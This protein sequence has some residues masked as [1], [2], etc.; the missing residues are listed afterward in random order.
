MESTEVHI[1]EQIFQTGGILDRDGNT[2]ESI[3]EARGVMFAIPKVSDPQSNPPSRKMKITG[4]K[5]GL[6]ACLS[7]ISKLIDACIA[8]HNF[9]SQPLVSGLTLKEKLGIKDPVPTNARQAY[10][11]DIYQARNLC[12]KFEI[13]TFEEIWHGHRRATDPEG[14]YENVRQAV[15]GSK[16]KSEILVTLLKSIVTPPIFYRT[17]GRPNAGSSQYQ[18]D[19]DASESEDGSEGLFDEANGTEAEESTEE[20]DDDDD[21]SEPEETPVVQDSTTFINPPTE[22]KS[23]EP[24]TD[25]PSGTPLPPIAKAKPRTAEKKKY[26]RPPPKPE[27]GCQKA[28]KKACV[29]LMLLPKNTIMKHLVKR[30]RSNLKEYRL[31]AAGATALATGLKHKSCVIEQLSVCNCDIEDAGAAALAEVTTKTARL[32]SLDL[33]QNKLGHRTAVALARGFRNRGG[34]S[35][36][37]LSDTGFGNTFLPLFAKA[38]KKSPCKLLSLNL[39]KCDISDRGARSLCKAI[40]QCVSL[41]TLNL[42]WNNIG[43]RSMYR[44]GDVISSHSTLINLH[45]A[46]NSLGDAGGI[47]FGAFLACSKSLV[48]VDVAENRLG[49]NAAFAI[50]DGIRYCRTMR[51][52]DLS[53]NPL[54]DDGVVELLHAR[55]ISKLN[56]LGLKGTDKTGGA[57]E[58]LELFLKPA[59][60]SRIY[61]MWL[62]SPQNRAFAQLLRLRAAEGG[63][64]WALA[65]LNRAVLVYKP[66]VGKKWSVPREGLL[67]IDYRAGRNKPANQ[68]HG[69]LKLASIHFKLD[70]SVARHRKMAERLILLAVVELGENWFNETFN[71]D[72]FEFDEQVH[73]AAWLPKEGVLEFD[74]ASANFAYNRPFRFDLSRKQEHERATTLAEKCFRSKLWNAGGMRDQWK[75]VKVK[76]E[77][78]SLAKYTKISKHERIQHGSHLMTGIEANFHL[79]SSGLLEFEY[80]TKSPAYLYSTPYTLD[81][82]DKQQHQEAEML[83]YRAAENP[84]EVWWGVLIDGMK[85]RLKNISGEFAIPKR[86][87]LTFDYLYYHTRA[88]VQR[89]YWQPYKFDLADKRQRQMC[90]TFHGQCAD[91]GRFDFFLSVSHDGKMLELKNV[92]EATWMVPKTGMLEFESCYFRKKPPLSNRE[93]RSLLQEVSCQNSELLKLDILSMSCMGKFFVTAA[94]VGMLC[95]T[96]GT[97][98]GQRDAVHTMLPFLSDL[99]LEKDV[100]EMLQRSTADRHLWVPILRIGNLGKVKQGIVLP[101]L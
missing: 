49:R 11:M 86:G 47:V 29:K 22:E 89:M 12:A 100:R 84:G 26:V 30:K 5:D 19:S 83:Y 56:F 17:R 33:S 8:R 16:K 79:P 93:F 63:N 18:D 72:P 70:L 24:E 42:D 77:S 71:G 94:M 2:L 15:V 76:G 44:L 75:N 82:S 27:K 60:E 39:S 88:V 57:H 34:L 69:D 95:R 31:G 73:T 59:N 9:W 1:P 48:N 98:E 21:E 101:P 55:K 87:I 41:E 51:S 14:F 46:W 90:I 78:A 52:L 54:G 20:E 40:P 85:A 25:G 43:P 80:C 6:H 32:Y 64:R 67:E 65:R 68:R 23:T 35:S 3:R 92:Q 28:Y 13:S 97:I 50:A 36:L 61:E 96:F 58:E 38:I 37:N 91:P 99:H 10:G 53:N 45:L 66:R 4:S 81:L 74:Y 7:D 62:N